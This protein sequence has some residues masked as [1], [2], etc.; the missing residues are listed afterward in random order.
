LRESQIKMEILRNMGIGQGDRRAAEI[1]RVA[2]IIAENPQAALGAQA[3]ERLIGAENSSVLYKMFSG[4]GDKM[5][6][7]SGS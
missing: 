5:S 4:W 2:A 6:L 1:S 7:G 3:L